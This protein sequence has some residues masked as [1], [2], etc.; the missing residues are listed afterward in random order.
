MKASQLRDL[1][2]RFAAGKIGREEYEAE[3]RQMIDGIVS[4]QIEIRY[5]ELY[6]AKPH[7]SR[8]S[9]KRKQW[10]VL[11]G[12][13]TLLALLLAAF[14]AHF[15]QSPTAADAQSAQTSA[16]EPGVDV[17][18]KF[19]A[20]DDWSEPALNSFEQNWQALNEFQREAARRNHLHRRLKTET[21]KRIREYEALM[22]IDSGTEHA[23][24]LLKAAR[25]RAFSERLGLH[26]AR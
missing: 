14:A 16:R 8:S 1:A 10:L 2:R 11:G 24:A 6:P 20:A 3:R 17:L 18:E 23:D 13:A 19:L 15:Q 22:A 9:V 7:A 21:D 25:L 12:G 4:G 5:R 26:T